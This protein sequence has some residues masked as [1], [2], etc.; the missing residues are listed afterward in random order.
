MIGGYPMA[1][2][3]QKLFVLLQEKGIKKYHLRQQGIHANVMDK[4]IKN[5]NVNV[6]TINKLC[7]ILECQPCDI[8]EY[9]PDDET[10]S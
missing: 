5:E 10:K 8:M 3:Y 9:V 7:Q 1:I 4:L 6:S 2:S